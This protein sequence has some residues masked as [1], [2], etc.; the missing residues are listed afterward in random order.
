[1]KEPRLAPRPFP[2]ARLRPGRKR[3]R[4]GTRRSGLTP[5]WIALTGPLLAAALTGPLLATALA[6]IVLTAALARIMLSA[7]LAG[8][9]MLSA[10]GGIMLTKLVLAG[11]LWAHLVSFLRKV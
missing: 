11:F 10:L 3:E 7:T 5:V 8:V 2:R 6:R 4:A 1:M 9:L